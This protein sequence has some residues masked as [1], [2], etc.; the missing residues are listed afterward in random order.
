MDEAGG[1]LVVEGDGNSGLVL[2]IMRRIHLA[3]PITSFIM[4][5]M[6]PTKAGRN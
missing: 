3:E 4:V 1:T 6:L 2:V 5:M